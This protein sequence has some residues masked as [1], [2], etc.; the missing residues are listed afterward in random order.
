MPLSVF[1][2]LV[3]NDIGCRYHFHLGVLG[4]LADIFGHYLRELLRIEVQF[5]ARNRIAVWIDVDASAVEGVIYECAL[6]KFENVEVP[7]FDGFR[8]AD[9]EVVVLERFVDV[10]QLTPAKGV[11]TISSRSAADTPPL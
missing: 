10:L 1:S 8:N 6:V 9:I 7:A 4:N 3:I 11:L 2:L 5:N